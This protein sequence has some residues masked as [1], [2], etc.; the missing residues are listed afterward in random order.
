MLF[1]NIITCIFCFISL[2][3]I[4]Y[5]QVYEIEINTTNFKDKNGYKQGYW[6][7]TIEKANIHYTITFYKNNIPNGI[8][9][10]FYNNE[11]LAT[12][13]FFKNGKADSIW[14]IYYETGELREKWQFKEGE[15]TGR[16]EEYT[17]DGELNKIAI[18]E[19]MDDKKIINV[20]YRI[21]IDGYQLS[22]DIPSIPPLHY[23]DL[24]Y[25]S[26]YESGKIAWEATYKDKK[27]DGT[28][29]LY[30]DDSGQIHFKINWKNGEKHSVFVIYYKNGNI[31]REGFY[32]KGKKNGIWNEYFENGGLSVSYKYKNDELVKKRVY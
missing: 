30:Y 13:G 25:V 21:V 16:W 15:R 29:A 7:E 24:K 8:Y 1:K 5:S 2:N 28:M 6:K 14:Y 19:I 17:K 31:K 23:N 9:K 4:T 12:E 20:E 27:L 11:V 26:Y 10:T 22:R 3:V 18:Y 32:V